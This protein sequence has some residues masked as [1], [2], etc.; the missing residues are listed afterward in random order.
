MRH[1]VVLGAALLA[2]PAQADPGGAELAAAREAESRGAEIYAYD[3]A[4]WHST[5]RFQ[6]DLKKR[7]WSLETAQ[8]EGFSGYVVEPAGEGLLLATYYGVKDGKTIAMARYWVR[9]SK[10]QRGGILREGDD[11]ALSPLALKLIEARSSAFKTA[12]EQKVFLCT[13]GNPNTVVLPPRPDGSIPAYVMSSGVQAGV[14][15]AGG[16]YRYVFDADGKLLSSRAFS[17]SCVNVD[18]RAVPKKASGFGVSHLLDPQPTEVHVFVSYNVPITLFVI[19][20]SNRSLW[21][22]D[23]GK[24][25]F[26]QVMQE[27]P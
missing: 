22:V 3:Q 27:Q 17:K 18:A 14:F 11:P 5:D 10:V 21:E 2:A 7:K 13:K 16:H 23:R 8:K 15:P 26:K 9:G 4:A 1:L 6:D 24:V 12:I 19:T 25:T 20:E